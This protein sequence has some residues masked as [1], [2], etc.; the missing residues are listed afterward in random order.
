MEKKKERESEGERENKEKAHV[1]VLCTSIRPL[2]LDQWA[3]YRGDLVLGKAAG[4]L[5]PHT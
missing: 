2:P 4:N 1:K 5:E 3:K